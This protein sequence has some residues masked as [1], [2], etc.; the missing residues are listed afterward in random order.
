M[1]EV[2]KDFNVIQ[3]AKMKEYVYFFAHGEKSH[4]FCASLMTTFR[5]VLDIE[6]MAK[7]A[8]LFEGTHNF[9]G[10]CSKTSENGLYIRSVDSC[11]LSDNTMITASFFPKKSHMLKVRGEGFGYNQIRTMVGT[12]VKL[13]KNQIDLDYISE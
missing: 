8:K 9:K 6:L 12:L 2:A 10:Y 4:P 1:R 7:G 13:G 11:D 3:D 5:D